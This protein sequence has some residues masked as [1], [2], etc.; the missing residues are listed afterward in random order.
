M[1]SLILLVT[2]VVLLT[3]VQS[4]A[5]PSVDCQSQPQAGY[6]FCNTKL[7]AEERASDLVILLLEFFNFSLPRAT[8][9]FFNWF[10]AGVLKLPMGFCFIIHL[11]LPRKCEFF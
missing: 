8:L 2:T 1:A 9:N 5:K 3:A 6:D 4:Y 7:T 10:L 11:D